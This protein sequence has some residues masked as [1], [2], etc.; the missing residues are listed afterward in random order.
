MV[1]GVLG[2]TSWLG[3]AEAAAM[4]GSVAYTIASEDQKNCQDF[5]R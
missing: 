3:A 4:W 2:L 1:L 5:Y